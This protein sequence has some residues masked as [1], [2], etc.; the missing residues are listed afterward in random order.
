MQKLYAVIIFLLL[1]CDLTAH[2]QRFF[3]LTSEQVS[4][5]SV[6]PSFSYSVPLPDNYADSTYSMSILYPEFIDM[7]DADIANYHRMSQCPLPAL[8]TAESNIIFDRKRPSLLV[9]FC[10]LVY[11]DGKYQILVSFMLRIDAKANKQSAKSH[12]KSSIVSAAPAMASVTA[13]TTTA[14]D[15]YAAHSV[16]AEGSWAKIR[17]PATGVY[18]LTAALARQAG[19]SDISKVRVYGY[20]GNLQKE[21]LD[22]NDLITY[23]DLK[24]VPTCNVNGHRLFYAKGPVSWS[25]KEATRRTRNPYSDYGYYSSPPAMPHRLPLTPQHSSTPSIPLPTTTTRS[26]KSTATAGFPVAATSSTARLC[27]SARPRRSSS[28]TLRVP[29][30]AVSPSTSPQALPVRHW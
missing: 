3:N 8:P 7:S 9:S 26:M 12:A 27:R 20:G 5:D 10:P 19:F 17:V 25:S 6:M 16:L 4:V 24:E 28:P 22:G 1:Q 11:R 30:R 23:D 2:A 14:A 18:E 15:R 29:R 21:I 13:T